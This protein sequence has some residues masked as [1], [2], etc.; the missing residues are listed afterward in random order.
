MGLST[1]D[2]ERR[3]VTKSGALLRSETWTQS[4]GY[5]NEKET[6]PGTRLSAD[7]AFLKEL[8]AANPG[9]C[10]VVGLSLYRRLPRYSS[11]NDEFGLYVPPYVR[12][13]LIEEDGIARTL[14]SNN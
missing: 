2:N 4:N 11:D 9:H 6:I 13:Y 14:K 8:L 12:Y 7:K 1:I 5:G 10:L 3:W